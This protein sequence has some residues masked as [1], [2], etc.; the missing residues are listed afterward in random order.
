M[1]VVSRSRILRSAPQ[2]TAKL[3][4]S[5][6]ALARPLRNA[7]DLDPL[8][9]RIGDARYVL[10]GEASHGTSEYYTWRFHISRRL[11]EEKGFSFIAVE[12]DWPDCYRVNRFVRGLSDAGE[13]T[14]SVLYAFARWPTWMWANEEVI[15]L[16]DWLR[17]HNERLP[18]ERK[19][20][21]YGLDVYSLWDSLYS[22]LGHLRKAP[23]RPWL[24]L[25]EPSS[26]SSPMA[27]TPRS[28]PAPPAGWMRRARMRWWPCWRRCGGPLRNPPRTTKKNTSTPS[29]T[30]WW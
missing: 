10:L 17:Q 15:V 19:A 27:R 20:G 21:F 14:R 9:E 5:I 11:I 25:A 12:G 16:C 3:S 24:L 22:V 18:Q 23:P 26:V 1:G 29:R 13:Y 28:T 4:K 30:P 7:D 6:R 2:Y 8:M